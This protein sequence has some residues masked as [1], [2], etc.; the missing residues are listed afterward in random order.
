MTT[1]MTTTMPTT[2]NALTVVSPRITT[3]TTPSPSA[4]IVREITPYR[5]LRRPMALTIIAALLP[6][7][8]LPLLVPGRLLLALLLRRIR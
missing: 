6:A 5:K 8:F 1:I 2:T 3:C 4:V 7:V